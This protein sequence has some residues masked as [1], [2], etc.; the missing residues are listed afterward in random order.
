MTRKILTIDDCRACPFSKAHNFLNQGNPMSR[1]ELHCMAIS[2]ER[3]KIGDYAV[4]IRIEIPDW[5][6]LV[7]ADDLMEAFVAIQGKAVK[8]G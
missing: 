7:D 4:G 6:P 5:C 8:N 1:T 2:N 3:R